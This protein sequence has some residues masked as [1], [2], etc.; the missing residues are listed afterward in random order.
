MYPLLDSQTLNL[1][2]G[3]SLSVCGRPALNLAT[4]CRAKEMGEE[5]AIA[6]EELTKD[7]GPGRRGEGMELRNRT[8]LGSWML[9]D[10]LQQMGLMLPQ[11]LPEIKNYEEMENRKKWERAH[12]TEREAWVPPSCAN[13]PSVWAV[14]PTPA[15][16]GP[17]QLSHADPPIPR[18]EQ[19]AST[20]A[21]LTSSNPHSLRAGPPHVQPSE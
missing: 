17:S 14:V 13:I 3:S 21:H 20:G 16:E 7:R 11:M 2:S 6:L 12:Q 15:T 10:C 5:E 1:N 19:A 18:L 4:L 9:S 8:Q